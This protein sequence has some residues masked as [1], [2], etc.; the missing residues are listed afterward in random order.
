MSDQELVRPHDKARRGNE[1]GRKVYDMEEDTLETG[2]EGHGRG[3]GLDQDRADHGD[4]EEEG[5]VPK[6]KKIVAKP[7]PEEV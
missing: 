7:T 1:E 4:E 5:L 3:Q 2:A 6:V